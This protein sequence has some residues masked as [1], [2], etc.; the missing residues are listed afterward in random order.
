MKGI[1][2]AIISGL[3]V[4]LVFLPVLH[5]GGKI[6][7]KEYYEGVTN[8]V[9]EKTSEG[10]THRNIERIQEDLRVAPK[11][12][13]LLLLERKVQ[14][15]QQLSDAEMTQATKLR[16][17]IE[18]IRRIDQKWS[19]VDKVVGETVVRWFSSGGSGSKMKPTGWNQT[20]ASVH[21]G[22]QVEI[23][24]G[25]GSTWTYWPSNAF[26]TTGPEGYCGDISPK[27]GGFCAGQALIRF[28]NGRVQG[29]TNSKIVADASGPIFVGIAD[30]GLS[31]NTGFLMLSDVIVNGQ[32][33]LSVLSQTAKK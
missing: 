28:G 9:P 26:G 13:K 18:Q 15:G 6:S 31:D 22:D 1:I 16:S 30:S 12:E 29:W 20:P 33:V 14:G 8:W 4:F 17:E 7:L 21:A 2:I 32:S 27:T 23:V 3:L 25:P 10:Y 11:A 19:E 5:M 24:F